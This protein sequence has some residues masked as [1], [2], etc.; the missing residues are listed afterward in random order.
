MYSTGW[1]L[2]LTF[3]NCSLPA[4]L[5]HGDL[6]AVW[7]FP[8]SMIHSYI[9]PFNI[10]WASVYHDVVGT[11]K[12][13]KSISTLKQFIVWWKDRVIN[14]VTE[15]KIRILCVETRVFKLKACFFI[16]KYK[17][18]IEQC[19]KHTPTVE[20]ILMELHFMHFL[21]LLLLFSI[22]WLIYVVACSMFIAV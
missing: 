19:I 7:D 6:L 1:N 2:G 22:M 16:V 15:M 4:L 18:H 12:W 17:I 11:Q 10:C 14:A 3:K 9:Y 8:V 21:W 20:Q 13:I 5:P